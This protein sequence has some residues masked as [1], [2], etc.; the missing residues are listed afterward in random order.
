MAWVMNMV[1]KTFFRP[2]ASDSQAQKRRPRPLKIE[3]MARIVPPARASAF[4]SVIPWVLPMIS[5]AIGDSCES[6]P[7]PAEMFRQSMAHSIHH[8]GVFYGF[9]KGEGLGGRSRR[10][11]R[12]EARGK[13]ALGG[14]LVELGG[15]RH[16]DQEDDAPDIEGGGHAH[17]V[18][19]PPGRSSP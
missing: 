10:R 7:R 13:P 19:H 1:M 17:A 2:I 18:D 6:R 16:Q 3:A 5:C 11:R 15:G 12:R 9:V 4:G 8:C 14:V